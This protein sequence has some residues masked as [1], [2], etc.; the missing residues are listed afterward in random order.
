MSSELDLKKQKQKQDFTFQKSWDER[1][2][3]IAG[4]IF[5]VERTTPR[6]PT[7]C[8]NNGMENDE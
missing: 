6:K 1:M 7:K 8:K 3:E 2:A 4:R 5:Q